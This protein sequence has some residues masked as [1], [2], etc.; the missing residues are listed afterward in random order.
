MFFCF[1]VGWFGCKSQ[2]ANP[3]LAMNK[4]FMFQING[5]LGQELAGDRARKS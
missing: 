5:S 2:I 1:F 4:D 3:G